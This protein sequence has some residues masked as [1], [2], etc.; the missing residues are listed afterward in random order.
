ATARW[1][2]ELVLQHQALLVEPLEELSPTDRP[3]FAVRASRPYLR[4][5]D[6]ATRTVS[7][8]DHG[9]VST[10][11]LG[12]KPNDAVIP[13][14]PQIPM[15]LSVRLDRRRRFR[16][17]IGRQS[18]CLRRQAQDL[19]PA[20][21]CGCV[22]FPGHELSSSQP[23]PLP[24]EER[25]I[26]FAPRPTLRQTWHSP[27]DTRVDGSRHAGERTARSAASEDGSRG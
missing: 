24:S 9:R 23:C 16:R 7:V 2:L 14:A 25:A 15:L 8:L 20:C 26:R 27:F 21:L 22:R 3:R 12:P 1:I 13:R 11:R 5:P 4:E 18:E 6:H 17:S 10:A 19:C